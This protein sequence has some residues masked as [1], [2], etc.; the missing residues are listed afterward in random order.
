MKVALI[1]ED[2]WVECPKNVYVVNNS[3]QFSIKINLGELPEGRFHY[4]QI[5]A[6]DVE[7]ISK[8]CVFRIPITIIKP[9][10]YVA[11]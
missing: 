7:N 4:T 1:S 10:W 3:K 2:S 8:S 5:K 11:I 9:I 6:Y